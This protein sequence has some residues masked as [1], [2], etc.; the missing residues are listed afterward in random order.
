ML[1]SGMIFKILHNK[2]SRGTNQLEL[3]LA[4]KTWYDRTSLYGLDVSS[5][6]LIAITVST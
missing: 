5:V 6:G 1:A 2:Y 4:V 3:L